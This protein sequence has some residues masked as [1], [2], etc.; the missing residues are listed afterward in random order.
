MKIGRGNWSTRRKPASTPLCPPQI[1]IDQTRVWTRAAAVGS[2]RLTAWAMAR[3]NAVYST[4][5]A[6]LLNKSE[7]KI[8]ECNIT[9]S[10]TCIWVWD[11]GCHRNGKHV[12]RPRVLSDHQLLKESVPAVNFLNGRR[13]NILQANRFWRWGSSIHELEVI[14]F[15]MVLFPPRTALEFREQTD[16]HRPNTVF[17]C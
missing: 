3:P 16:G 15:K 1:P 7:I 2:P 13:W 10:F 6:A 8:N 17:L 4:N 9:C 5:L 12:L 14:N 11:L